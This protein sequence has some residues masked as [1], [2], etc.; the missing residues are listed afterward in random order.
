MLNQQP[1]VAGF[2]QSMGSRFLQL[3]DLPDE[4]LLQIISRTYP[5]LTRLSGLL[6]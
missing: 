1:P 5:P 4:L 6:T 3:L 2:Q